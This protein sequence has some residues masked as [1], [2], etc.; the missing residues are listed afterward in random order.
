[1][2]PISVQQ[3]ALRA[4]LNRILGTEAAVRV[5]RVLALSNDPL[6]RGE[7][8]ER[9]GLFRGGL[10]R[11]LEALE[12]QG[13]IEVIGQGRSRP[14]R[15]RHQHPLTQMLRTLFQ[16]EHNRAEQV[17]G[18][19]R[20]AA[21]Q[22]RPIPAAV[23]IEG[24]VATSTDQYADPLVIGLLAESTDADGWHDALRAKANL[25]QRQHDVAIEIRVMWRADVLAMVPRELERLTTVI[26]IVGPPPLD[27]LGL[28]QDATESALGQRLTQ[29]VHDLNS[30]Q[31]G[32]SLAR[33]LQKRPGLVADTIRYLERRI[34]AA[35]TREALELQEWKDILE[36]YAL[37]RL[38][39]F[40]QSDSERATRLRQS[41]PFVHVLS[42]EDRLQVRTESHSLPQ[43]ERHP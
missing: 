40:L 5:L 17:L 42:E 32:V 20:S 11:V 28:G 22:L 23:W 4:P 2:R 29:E 36:T 33:L 12:N 34:P 24:T 38:R 35:S 18:E 19:I 15:L 14:L 3:S 27:L 13:V 30:R 6:S 8:A 39:V 21:M 31:Y 16:T 37:G 10:P 1:M 9:S 26:P 41:A 43:A 25:L 7:I